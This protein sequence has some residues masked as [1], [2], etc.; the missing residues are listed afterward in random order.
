[1]KIAD[2]ICRKDMQFLHWW[3]ALSPMLGDVAFSSAPPRSD[4]FNSSPTIK[5][6]II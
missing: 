4:L 1:L 2:R 5:G 6:S 3:L